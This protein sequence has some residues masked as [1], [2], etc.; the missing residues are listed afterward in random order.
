MLP[1]M[2]T[3]DPTAGDEK[4]SPSY[5]AIGGYVGILFVTACAR[6][7][8]GFLGLGDEYHPALIVHW[9][10][11][12]AV[13]AAVIVLAIV[14]CAFRFTPRVPRLRLWLRPLAASAGLLLAVV[15]LYHQSSTEFDRFPTA[16]NAGRE[17]WLLA[18]WIALACPFVAAA[19]ARFRGGAA[20][21]FLVS[22]GLTSL[23]WLA[24]QALDVVMRNQ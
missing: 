6:M 17:Y 12:Y 19:V 4:R 13:V 16:G 23:V 11:V 5:I 10:V 3:S 21:I 14:A 1:A 9:A 2:T 8:T 20:R 22:A 7:F 18:A 24:A 15:L